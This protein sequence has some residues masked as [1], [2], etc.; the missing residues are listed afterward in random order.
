MKIRKSS[1][2]KE[3]TWIPL[4]EFALR[5]GCKEDIFAFK[6]ALLSQS[7]ECHQRLIKFVSTCSCEPGRWRKE[8]PNKVGYTALSSRSVS[9]NFGHFRVLHRLCSHC[10]PA[11]CL[12]MTNSFWKIYVIYYIFSFIIKDGTVLKNKAWILASQ[13]HSFKF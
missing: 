2:T 3:A 10:L 12:T 13:K 5:N 4:R 1:S 6:E 7:A 9:Q 8:S 11:A